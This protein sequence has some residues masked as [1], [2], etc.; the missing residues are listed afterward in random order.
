MVSGIRGIHMLAAAAA[1]GLLDERPL[2]E[3]P[4]RIPADPE[5]ERRLQQERARQSQR[6]HEQHAWERKQ[7]RER[8]A[9]M[10]ERLLRQSIAAGRD[11]RADKYLHAAA[12]RRREAERAATST[13]A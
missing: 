1:L 13:E 6:R 5:R 4:R 3:P 11:D 7:R 10:R 8:E 2:P 9:E 12:R